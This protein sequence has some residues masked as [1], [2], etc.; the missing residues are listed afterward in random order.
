MA[1]EKHAIAMSIFRIC[2]AEDWELVGVVKAYNDIQFHNVGRMR[3]CCQVA[4]SD[5]ILYKSL[6]P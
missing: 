3:T 4:M 5:T 2:V 1:D 6:G